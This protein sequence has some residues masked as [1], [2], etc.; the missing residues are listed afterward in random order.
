M[1]MDFKEL[2]RDEAGILVPSLDITQM[3]GAY[4]MTDGEERIA[5]AVFLP[6]AASPAEAALVYLELPIEDDQAAM[7][8][9][10]FE[11]CF[12]SLK[13]AGIVSIYYRSSGAYEELAA[14]FPIL[15]N[16]GFDPKVYIGDTLNGSLCDFLESDFLKDFSG[17]E[18]VPQAQSMADGIPEKWMPL[19][20]KCCSNVVIRNHFFTDP[21]SYIYADDNNNGGVLGMSYDLIGPSINTT[22]VEIFAENPTKRKKILQTLLSSFLTGLKDSLPE[23]TRICLLLDEHADVNEA[24]R[25]F[26]GL[27]EMEHFQEFLYVIN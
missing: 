10:F 8:N 2:S 23:Y 3:I 4:A 9:R 27:V 20:Q 26:K 25:L 19:F 18:K 21:F 16:A 7:M 14:R 6:S 12:K 11:T 1:R 22:A 17:D 15:V 24:E 5:S 13:K